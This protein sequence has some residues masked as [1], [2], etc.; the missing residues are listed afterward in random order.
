MELFISITDILKKNPGLRRQLYRLNKNCLFLARL[1]EVGLEGTTTTDIGCPAVEASTQGVGMTNTH[2]DGIDTW[3]K[4]KST[5]QSYLLYNWTLDSMS[6]TFSSFKLG[7]KRPLL[8]LSGN[9]YP[10]FN[11]DYI[12]YSSESQ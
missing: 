10:N 11:T 12:D 8:A 1:V 9:T 2:L 7:N 3:C 6:E 5:C 4:K